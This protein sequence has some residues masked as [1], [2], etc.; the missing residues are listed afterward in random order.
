ME[1][2]RKGKYYQIYTIHIGGIKHYFV[3][4]I[5]NGTP[6]IHG[7]TVWSY[8]NEEQAEELFERAETVGIFWEKV[9]KEN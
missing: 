3:G 9:N 1:I 8:L 5:K 6:L 7:G 4:N 2:I